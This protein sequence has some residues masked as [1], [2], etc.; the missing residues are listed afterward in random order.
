MRTLDYSRD[1]FPPTQL[2]GAATVASIQ[3]LQLWTYAFTY[4]IQWL[5]LKMSE[6]RV[7][8]DEGVWLRTARLA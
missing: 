4:M 7:R 3:R 6:W 1:G 5:R 2:V 8:L